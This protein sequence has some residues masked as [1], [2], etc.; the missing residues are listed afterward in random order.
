MNDESTNDGDLRDE[1]SGE[2]S[3]RNPT[4]SALPFAGSGAKVERDH[5]GR[6]LCG[7]K[8]RGKNK[9]CRQPAIRPVGR[10]RLHGGLTPIGIASPHFKHG[11]RSKYHL[12]F[13]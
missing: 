12:V 9:R 1:S 7:A 4:P 5:L 6:Q 10:C 11:R 8:C 13:S 3:D 2:D